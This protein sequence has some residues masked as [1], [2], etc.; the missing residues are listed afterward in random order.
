MPY[1]LRYTARL[2]SASTDW[3]EKIERSLE[4]ANLEAKEIIILG[5]FNFNLLNKPNDTLQWTEAT[6]NFN[7]K[8]L[9]NNPTRVTATTQTLIDH[10]YTNTPDNIIDV[11]VP[12]FAISDHY[13]VGIANIV[14]I[15]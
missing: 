3:S 12:V 9:V 15:F 4:H 13:P 2:P 11:S 10:A 7:F 6:D 1:R 5:D 8:H 14:K